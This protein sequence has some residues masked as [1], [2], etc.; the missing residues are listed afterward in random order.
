MSLSSENVAFHDIIKNINL[1]HYLYNQG[2]PNIAYALRSV[3]SQCLNLAE[4][5][6]MVFK[7][8]DKDEK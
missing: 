6:D 8:D 2:N 1:I 5:F 7:Q 3:A 4:H